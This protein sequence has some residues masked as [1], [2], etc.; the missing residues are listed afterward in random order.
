[1]TRAERIAAFPR[2]PGERIL[3]LDRAMGTMI[4]SHKPSEAD[5]RATSRRHWL[6][7]LKGNNDLLTL[8]RPQPIL[9]A[10]ARFL[11][12]I[13]AANANRQALAALAM[14]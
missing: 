4:P 14:A 5:Y 12:D 11:G 9:D 2:L 6:S 8:A 10:H 3:A 13:V 7:D 1:M